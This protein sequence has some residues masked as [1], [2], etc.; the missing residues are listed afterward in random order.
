ML[1]YAQHLRVLPP[2]VEGP[3][4]FAFPPDLIPS[5]ATSAS[6]SESD[7][8]DNDMDFEMDD[9]SYVPP[10]KQYSYAE[11][12]SGGFGFGPGA[13]EDELTDDDDFSSS[14][15][16]SMYAHPTNAPNTAFPSSA[17]APVSPTAWNA[18][19]YAQN[20]EAPKG[21]GLMQPAVSA[22]LADDATA[23]ERARAQHG[24]HC[25]SIPKLRMSDYPNAITGERSLWTVC[26]DCGAMEMAK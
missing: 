1:T 9:A 8:M 7:R 25:T 16:P 4:G 2:S 22:P 10:Q 15:Y 19:P 11:G 12:G 23:V 26:Q 24:P 14:F 18:Q 13:D 6:V 5:S 20:L 17:S 3:N 21:A